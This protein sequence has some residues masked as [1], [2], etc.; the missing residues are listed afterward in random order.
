MKLSIIVPVYNMAADGKLEYCLDSLAAQTIKDYEVI[1]VDDAS[2]DNS[3]E[4]LRAYEKKYPANSGQS[5]RK[6][7]SGRAAQKTS[8]F[9][10]QRA[11]GSALSTATTGSCQRC[12]SGSSGAPRKRGPIWQAAITA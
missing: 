10:W 1:A 6:K 3:L 5:I 4:I 12:M 9:R 11:S 8:G 7:T 2:T